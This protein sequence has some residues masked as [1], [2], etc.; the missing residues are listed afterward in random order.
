MSA[1]ALEQAFLQAKGLFAEIKKCLEVNKSLQW[2]LSLES[3]KCA[4]QFIDTPEALQFI[5]EYLYRIML[6][7]T[8]QSTSKVGTFEKTVIDDSILLSLKILFKLLPSNPKY[9]NILSRI[10]DSSIPYYQGT[11]IGYTF[12]PGYPMIRVQMARRFAEAKGFYMVGE[13][14]KKS[15]FAWLGSEIM[16]HILKI[17][18]VQEVSMHVEDSVKEDMVVTIMNIIISLPDESLKKENLDNLNQVIHVVGQLCGSLSNKAQVPSNLDN[19]YAFWF[20][21]TLKCMNSGSLVLKL[22]SWEQINELITEAKNSRPIANSYL[23]ENAGT[24]YVNGVYNLVNSNGDP[25][26]TKPSNQSGKPMLT[27]FRCTMRTKAKWWFISHADLEKPG[28]DKDIDYYLHKSNHDEER[29][30]PGRGWT[31]NNTG[32]NLIGLDPAPI[33]KRNGV[34]LPKGMTKEMF[35]DSKL[36]SWSVEKNFVAYIFGQSIHREIISRSCKFLIFLAEYNAIS[37]EQ[38]R[39]IWKA[40]LTNNDV[41]IV[42]EIFSLLIPLSIY[43]ERALFYELIDLAISSLA[44]EENLIKVSQFTEKFAQ[45]N[46][47][48][49]NGVLSEEAAAKFLSLVWSLYKSPTFE[50]LKNYGIIQDLLSNC[51]NHKNGSNL[52]YSLIIE[53]KNMLSGF[54]HTGDEVSISRIIQILQFLISKH[55][56]HFIIE[57]LEQENFAQHLLA[58]INR[59]VTVNQSK[60]LNNQL[61]E[62]WYAYQLANRLQVLRKFY[63][64]TKSVLMPL[65]SINSLWSLLSKSP[66]EVEEF[67]LFLKS[68]NQQSELICSVQ[69]SLKLFETFICNPAIDWANCGENAFDCFSTYFGELESGSNLFPVDTLLPPKLGLETLWRIALNITSPT[70]TKSAIDLLLTAYDTIS[71]RE[72]DAYSD[73]LKIIFTH[74]NDALLASSE[75]GTGLSIQSMTKVSRCIS[76]LNSAI[77]KAKGQNSIPHAVEGCMSRIVISVYYRRI[78]SY[79]N[80]NTHSDIIRVEKGTDGVVK[81][82]VH[83]L[84]TFLQLKEK[85]CE[86]VGLNTTN[87]VITIDNMNKN[88]VND[89]TRLVELGLIDGS[90]LSVSYQITFNNHKSYEDDYFVR[91]ANNL[92]GVNL[93]SSIS[94]NVNESRIPNIGQIIANDYSQFDCL[95]SLCELSKD[96]EISNKIWELLMLIPTQVDLISSIE[97]ICFPGSPVIED[98]AGD[99]S[100]VNKWNQILENYSVTR[101]TYL[102]QI[103]DNYLQPAPEINDYEMQLKA[104][105]FKASFIDTSGFTMVLKILISTPT[106]EVNKINSI[107]LAVA[108]HIIYFLLFDNQSQSFSSQSL[109]DEIQQSS[110]AVIEKLLYVARNAAAHEETGV[111]HNALVIITNLIKTPE[112]ASQL[113]NN[114]QSKILLATVLR[115][116]S[117]KVRVMA[118]DFAVQVG[119]SQPIVL[120]WLFDEL[121]NMNPNDEFCSEIFYAV[122][123]LLHDLH[124]NG[125]IINTNELASILSTKLSRYPRGQPPLQ[126]ERYVLLGYLELLDNLIDLDYNAVIAT[127]LGK[128]FVKT[129]MTEFLFSLPKADLDINSLCDTAATRQ[130]AFKVVASFARKSKPAFEEVLEELSKLSTMAAK[131]MHYSWG[132]QVSHDVK[133]ADMLFT[134]L[135]NQGCTCYLNALLQ[136]L[137]MSVNFREAILNTPIND[138]HRTS[139]WHKTDGELVGLKL[140]FE[141]SNGSWRVG[142]VESFDAETNSH[143]IIYATSDGGVDETAVFNVHDGRMQRET[144]RV[145]MLPPEGVELEPMTEREDAAYRV[146]EQ[147][148]RAFCFMKLSKRRYFDPRP[149]VEVCKTL[150]LNFNV[151]HQNDAAEFCDQLLDRIE[152]ATKG[153]HTKK[154]IWNEV[155][156]QNVF[157]GK[158]LYQK[159]PQDCETYNA[160]KTGCGHWQ[161]SR[162]ES[163]LK[164][165]LMIR[166]KEKIEES[167]EELMQG[168][169]MDGENKIHCDVCSEKKATVRRTCFGSLP[170]TLMLHLKRFDLDFQTFETVKLNNRMAFPVRINMLKYTKEGMEAEEKRLAKQVAQAADDSTESGSESPTKASQGKDKVLQYEQSDAAELDIEDYEYEL[171]GVL[172]HAGVA[173]GG[174]YYSFIR[175]PN[176]T[177]NK[178]YKFDDDDVTNFHPDNI[179]LQ[180]FGGS[181]SFHNNGGNMNEDDRTSNALMLFYNKVKKDSKDD[182][183]TVLERLSV[184]TSDPSEQNSHLVNGMQAFQREVKE[185]NLQHTLSIYLLDADLHA[186]VRGLI[187]SISKPLSYSY[188]GD[189]ADST[190]NNNNNNQLMWSPTENNDDLPLRTVKFG[191]VFLLDVVLHCRERAAM[192]ASINILRNAFDAYPSTAYWFI[193]QVIDSSRSSWMTDFLLLCTDALARATFVQLLIQA[194]SVIAPKDANMLSTIKSMKVVDL[195]REFNS[196]YNV[197]ALI[198]CLARTAIDY[199]FKAV[200]HVRTSDE[201]FVLVRDL[202]SIPC[203]CT[204]FQTLSAVAYLS[205]F[206]M[207]DVVPNNIKQLFEKNINRP[208]ARVDYGNLLQSVFEAMAALLGVPQ[209]R[210]VTLLQERTYW[211]ADLVPEAKEALTTIF[212]ESSHN[213]GM[214]SNDLTL[215]IDKVNGGN[216]QKVTTVH[217][218]GLLDR[219]STNNDG[220][221]SLDNFLQYHADTASYNPK[222]VWRDLHAFGFRND[223]SRARPVGNTNQDNNGAN[224][225][226]GIGSEEN[227]TPEQLPSESLSTNQLSISDDCRSCL[228]NISLYEIGMNASEASTRA[229]AQRV[230]YK[231]ENISAKF[232]EQALRKLYAISSENA[233]NHHPVLIINEFIRLLLSIDDGL[234]QFRLREI[235]NHPLCGLATIALNE[236]SRPSNCRANEFNKG[237]LSERYVTF[238]QELINVSGVIDNLQQL[239]LM[240]SKIKTIKGFLRLKQGSFLTENEDQAIRNTVVIVENAGNSEV[241]GEYHFKD[242]KLNAG[243]YSK[244]GEF[245]GKSVRFTL[246]K[247]TLKSGGYQWFISITPD[248]HEPGTNNDV[249]FYFGVSKNND[250]L[251]PTAWHRINANHTRD[252]PP[253]VQCVRIDKGGSDTSDDSEQDKD[254][255]AMVGDEG[256]DND[257]S[258]MSTNTPDNIYD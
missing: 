238:V 72:F 60:V 68:N 31:R 36:I 89:T 120:E 232:I 126:D 81:V 53:C 191:C 124:E 76:V 224:G 14:F 190:S 103:I 166:G 66:L 159:I 61:D 154:D 212:L 157:G 100:S 218:R 136:Q 129:F 49:L 196:S 250:K 52:T 203:I 79:Y 50:T 21:H 179:P 204:L 57:K 77:A 257:D 255:S 111:V 153:K 83:P 163:Y 231:D 109:L 235:L 208:N 131:H 97:Q 137:F 237:F 108:L 170:N 19:F 105:N 184:N 246:Y 219:F 213:G 116:G 164:V 92:S 142:T 67:F 228:S 54:E 2:N 169:L 141:Y 75:N 39:M 178:W 244:Q 241:N 99:T 5:D 34:L 156:L 73:M 3:I 140:L 217:V 251:P 207:P 16:L 199:V 229:I 188:S 175:D 65:D 171:Q 119:K 1:S 226:Q 145:R 30:P 149:F 135:K 125:K 12:S 223:L 221:L 78:V 42:D 51:L 88:L 158:W 198:V 91:N 227:K 58:E 194:V 143:R 248:D 256:N 174:H 47:K 35:F 114:S 205:Y 11:K 155:M 80:Q 189:S 113:T 254:I 181:S 185:S 26:Y 147:L 63:V 144:G 41:D 115:S 59:Y 110:A 252:P 32:I 230:C 233:W 87:T 13:I 71:Y 38:I 118:S 117:K 222:N 160:D 168:E 10:F 253:K 209:I 27:L 192:R 245:N 249:D 127:D 258:F 28:T 43:L 242:I 29:E 25:T 167:L 94:V 183:S 186:F 56:D 180:C 22:F 202:S 162:N 6:L 102:L 23:V 132:L 214:D 236:R 64:I 152:T 172:V 101:T 215:Y 4:F 206:V 195:K 151:Y 182:L 187:S 234:Q 148:Q 130:A 98:G 106:S 70:A 84:Q 200:N 7:M 55:G 146:L 177:E 82:E 17:L 243:Y 33:F 123:T 211:D 96:P 121:K 95:L 20:Q 122:S 173:Q 193:G 44:Q 176:S 240:D 225:A 37:V 8:N 15:D 85:L 210:K 139:V 161:S 74:L 86:L 247:C 165:E 133:K 134:G 46:F 69:D 45:D 197:N 239:A 18:T 40:A 201:I 138:Y 220:R 104:K 216:G 107:A 93:N 24:D 150:N 48:Y 9:L 62:K 128:S 90:D 112:V